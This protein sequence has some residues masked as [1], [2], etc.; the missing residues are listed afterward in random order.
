MQIELATPDNNNAPGRLVFLRES[1][2]I[3][4]IFVLYNSKIK[5]HHKFDLK[6]QWFWCIVV[7]KFNSGEMYYRFEMISAKW[8]NAY[9]QLK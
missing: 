5:V 8:L 3:N 6:Y 4:L 2:G 1:D 9:L 7:S